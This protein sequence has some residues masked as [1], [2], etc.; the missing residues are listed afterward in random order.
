MECGSNRCR[1]SQATPVAA[2][3]VNV[4]F[5]R[6][7]RTAAATLLLRKRWL[8]PTALQKMRQRSLPLFSGDA[9][10][11]ASHQGGFRPLRA[12]RRSFAARTKAVAVADRTPEKAQQPLP[13]P[14]D[15]RRRGCTKDPSASLRIN[16]AR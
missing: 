2:H 6:F 16:F 11:R 15:P 10:R 7:A 13:H 12:Y 4:D 1:F 5:D 9:S 3:R 14:A 8:S